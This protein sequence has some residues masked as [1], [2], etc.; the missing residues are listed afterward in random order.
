MGQRGPIARPT[1]LT[2]LLGNPGHRVLNKNEMQPDRVAPEIP[3]WLDPEALAEWERVTPVLLQLGVLTEID[4][5]ALSAYCMAYSRW[6]Q[7]EEIIS[8]KGLTYMT[9]TGLQARP[10]I[11]MQQ[12]YLGIIRVFCAE[13]G[14]TPSSRSRMSVPTAAVDTDSEGLD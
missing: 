14:L 11:T 4:R 13:F 12:K 9:K 10:E 8:A 5:T 6:V 2:R 1:E 7:C 3:S